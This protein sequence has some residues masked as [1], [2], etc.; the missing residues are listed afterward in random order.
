MN[1]SIPAEKDLDN[2]GVHP[3]DFLETVMT[4]ILSHRHRQRHENLP[5]HPFPLPGGER[6]FHRKRVGKWI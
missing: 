3:Y 5:P 4:K 2:I 1:K 6:G